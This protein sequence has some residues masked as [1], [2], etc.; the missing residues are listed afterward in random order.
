MNPFKKYI[1]TEWTYVGTHQT[2]NATVKITKA[3]VSGLITYSDI[4][5]GEVSVSH[6]NNFKQDYSAINPIE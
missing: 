6:W 2:Y 1:G 3:S 4:K 5:T